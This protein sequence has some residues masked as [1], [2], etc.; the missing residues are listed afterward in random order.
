VMG[1]GLRRR[2]RPADPRWC[3]FD[4]AARGGSP[5]GGRPVRLGCGLA[6]HAGMRVAL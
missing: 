2:W 4:S 6:P 3:G 1:L 5:S